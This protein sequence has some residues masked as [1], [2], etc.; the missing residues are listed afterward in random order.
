M[1]L[2]LSN[3]KTVEISISLYLGMSDFDIQDMIANNDGF[4]ASSFYVTS[5]ESV[6]CIDDNDDSFTEKLLDINGNLPNE[7][8]L[9][10]DVVVDE[11][12]YLDFCED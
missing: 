4:Y 9:E 6:R 2:E 5:F 12:K 8:V 1:L 7:Y 11:D 3:G 10:D